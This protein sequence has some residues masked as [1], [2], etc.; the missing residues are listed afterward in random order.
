[1]PPASAAA[2]PSDNVIPFGRTV[3]LGDA[4]AAVD[5]RHA[6]P[7]PDADDDDDDDD[8]IP[9]APP[10]A[11]SSPGVPPAG[12]PADDDED[13]D[14]FAQLA[15]KVT[16]TIG[17]GVLASIHRRRGFEP[18]ELDDD[19]VENLEVQTAKAVR[20]GL[21]DRAIPWWA[22]IVS[23]WGMAYFSMGNGAERLPPK[24]QPSSEPGASSSPPMQPPPA[25]VRSPPGKPAPIQPTSGARVA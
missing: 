19:E 15:A 16:T 12:A 10:A 17:I 7:A 23:A 18:N 9:D 11:P 5:L 4:L 8:E 2:A 13:P 20:R 6:G 14:S 21:G 25:Y 1:L 24:D 22:P 3:T